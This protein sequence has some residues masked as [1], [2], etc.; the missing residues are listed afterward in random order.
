MLTFDSS[1][2]CGGIQYRVLTFVVVSGHRRAELVEA[3]HQL[4]PLRELPA[5]F[6]CVVT[7]KSSQ[8]LAADWLIFAAKT[9]SGSLESIVRLLHPS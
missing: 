4:L 6:G 9:C 1:A 5:K 2:T 3:R 7:V 8:I